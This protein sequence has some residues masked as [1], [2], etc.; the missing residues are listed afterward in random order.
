MA[1]GTKH[2]HY[3][4]LNMIGYGL[5]K[6]DDEFIRLFECTTKTA[7]YTLCVKNG[8]A[9]T[10]GTIKNRMD[11]F[12]PFFETNNRRG[13]YQKGDTYIHR[14]HT[15][16]SLFGNHSAEEYVNAVKMMIN[17]L[18]A[19]KAL[20][21]FQVSSSPLV[22]SR[23]RKLQETG[24]EAESFFLNNYYQDQRFSLGVLTDARLYGDGYDF[25]I[26]LENQHHLIEV[27]GIRASKGTFRLTEKEYQQAQRYTDHY[28]IG[29]VKNLDVKPSLTFLQNPLYTL[30]F[31]AQTVTSATRTE[32]ILAQTI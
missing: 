27:K 24:F 26:S 8:I 16:D 15:I 12:D 2:E 20:P 19:P 9:Q 10:T 14:K 18:S 29:L 5:S 1:T 22:Q 13:W 3:A 11:L 4:L 32:Y 23:Y 31:R 7:F 28:W 17:D 25:Q 30:S 21:A 6:F